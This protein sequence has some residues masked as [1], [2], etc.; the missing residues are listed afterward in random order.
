ML[1]YRQSR[2]SRTSFSFFTVFAEHYHVKSS[3]YNAHTE[4]ERPSEKRQPSKKNKSKNTQKES[5]RE[6]KEKRYSHSKAS[7]DHLFH[8]HNY[9]AFP[10]PPALDEFSHADLCNS[11][12]MSVNIPPPHAYDI[13]FISFYRGKWLLAIKPLSFAN[14]ANYM[15]HCPHIAYSMTRKWLMCDFAPVRARYEW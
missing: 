15:R 5:E 9:F 13:N 12:N 7:N 14:G 3:E 8:V 1:K 11:V 2:F 10:F 6:K 4:R